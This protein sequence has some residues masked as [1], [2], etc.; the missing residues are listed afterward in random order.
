MNEGIIAVKKDGQS[1]AIVN[2]YNQIVGS[3]NEYL[4]MRLQ[5]LVDEYLEPPL[6]EMIEL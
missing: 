1:L 2:L 6:E 5:G 4:R 3:E